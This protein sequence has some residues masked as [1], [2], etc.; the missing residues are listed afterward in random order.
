MEVQEIAL[1][2]S[3]E[4]QIIASQALEV[5]VTLLE[6]EEVVAAAAEAALAYLHLLE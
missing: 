6:S 3:V 5:H 1:E 4:P 2:A